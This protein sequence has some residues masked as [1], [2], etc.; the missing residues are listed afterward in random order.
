MSNLNVANRTLAIMDNLRFLRSLNNECVDLIAIDPPFAANETFT[1]HPKPPISPEELEE[2]K[3]LAKRHGAPHNEGIGETRVKDVWNWDDDVHPD[4]KARI[5]DDYPKVFSVVQAVEDCATE[6]EAAYI[7]FMAARLIECHRV[8]KETGSIYIHCDT[9]ANGYLRMLLDAIFQAEN[10]RAEITWKRTSAHSDGKQGRKQHG[11][12]QD[13]LLFYT[14]SSRWTWNQVF[15]DY[16]RDYVD[17]F[18]RHI[19]TDTKRRFQTGDLTAAKP[20]GDTLY[21]WRV[22]RPE[23]GD[24]TADL[25][26]EWQNPVAGWE[27][28]GVPPSQG[29]YWA[30]SKENMREYAEQDR[31]VYLQ[32]GMP[33]YKRYLDEMP[34]VPLQDL[35]TDIKPLQSQSRERTG[36]PTQKPVELYER[37]IRASSNEGDVVLDI[38]AGCAT[39]AV[40]AERLKR[41]WIACDMAYRS[42]TM[43]KRR[44]YLN[45]YALTD[46]TDT[47]R[48]ALGKDRQTPLQ[49][50][51]SHTIGPNE[52]PQRNDADPMP[53]YHLR[54]TR[55]PTRST[56]NA[57]WS[58]RITKEE[59]KAL[60][61]K[62][63]GP[64][65]W[66]C[67]YSPRRPNGSVDE[68]L[69]EIDHIRARKPTE[70]TQGND[71]LYNLALLHRTCNAIKRN[72]TMTLQD[73]REHNELNALLWVEH[74]SQ[75]VDLFD[76]QKF[77]A[78]QY[79][80]HVARQGV[81]QV[82]LGDVG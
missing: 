82:L 57:S 16:D 80:L 32:S 48:V 27:Y 60:L 72:S 55:R 69:L 9:H 18:Y 67:G 66:G 39:T 5:Q 26:D 28:R 10:F 14:K 71:E 3:A 21:E 53:F 19:D 12:I 2:E 68:T 50:A 76:A 20:G 23:G 45:G 31:L 79:A 75:L 49:E 17:G 74:K 58:G 24:W 56:Q 73:L 63:F 52:L 7:C 81:Q 4:W 41:Q 30:Y 8:L 29:R 25:S 59:A 46:M 36:Y 11:R 43:L 40:A 70:G 78:E 1:S 77:A 64:V 6:N 62:E 47:T 37:I 42:W 35:W 34:G 44:F 13:K 65:C 38:F 61:V 51:K 15:T 54:Q 22:K 33:R